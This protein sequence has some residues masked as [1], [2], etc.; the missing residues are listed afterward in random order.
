V[1]DEG[2]EQL[3]KEIILATAAI[4]QD[5]KGVVEDIILIGGLSYERGSWFIGWDCFAEG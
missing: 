4:G 1:E 3:E 5:M 2:K